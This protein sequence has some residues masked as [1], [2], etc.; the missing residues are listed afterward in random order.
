MLARFNGDA[1]MFTVTF[2]VPVMDAGRLMGEMRVWLDRRRVVPTAFHCDDKNG[3]VE[4]QI[5][6]R[7]QAD[8]TACAKEFEGVAVNEGL[9]I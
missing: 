1:P 2:R 9:I 6:F 4:I 3:G 5:T 8:A 7:K